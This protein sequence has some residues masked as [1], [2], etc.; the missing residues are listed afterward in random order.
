MPDW[1]CRVGRK[2]FILI[3]MQP[4]KSSGWIQVFNGLEQAR[5]QRDLI[6]Q[7]LG[8]YADMLTEEEVSVVRSI[9]GIG[10]EAASKAVVARELR[11]SPARV[12]K[13]FLRACG[14][15]R[16]L[17]NP[18]PTYV[19]KTPE[20]EPTPHLVRQREP[21]RTDLS[22]AQWRKIE[23]LLPPQPRPRRDQPFD[24]REI[25][26]AVVY[27]LQTG[28]PWDLLPHDFPPY[29]IVYRYH[30]RW[31]EHGCLAAITSIV[32]HGG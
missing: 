30:Q 26:N 11:V 5:K 29:S 10:Q 8:R 24:L 7:A 23:P 22:D 20:P 25:A 18:E 32:R 6:E 1:G 2:L 15:L 14:K 12:N 9:V 27:R 21:Y 16:S 17:D 31:M 13:I 4:A 3:S 28:C 19:T